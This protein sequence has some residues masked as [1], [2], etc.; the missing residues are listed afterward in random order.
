MAR[1]ASSLPDHV[2]VLDCRMDSEAPG[3]M[4]G[5]EDRGFVHKPFHGIAGN[6]VRIFLPNGKILVNSRTMGDGPGTPL[7]S[8]LPTEAESSVGAYETVKGVLLPGVFQE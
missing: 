1:M 4:R 2:N 7:L 8:A 3:G 5:A 6:S